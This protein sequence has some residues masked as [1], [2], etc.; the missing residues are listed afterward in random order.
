VVLTKILFE[1]RWFGTLEASGMDFIFMLTHGDKTVENCLETLDEVLPLGLGHIG[2]KD[3]GVPGD[4]LSR[5]TQRIRDAGATS[6]MEVVSETPEACLRSAHVAVELGV[7]RLLG[8][9]D[10]DAI[11]AILE[12]SDIAYYPF[13][14]FPVD[15]PTRLRGQ[16]EEI[17]AH[18]RKFMHAGAAGVDLLA[19]RATDADPM[20]LVR[21]ARAALDEGELIVAG[22]I[23]SP[24]QVC[25]LRDAGVDGF[26]IGPAVFDGAFHAGG[27]GIAAQVRAVLDCLR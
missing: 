20:A 10:I 2:F 27:D 3:I 18:C 23:D 12:G 5:L 19:Y 9:T 15:H 13:P 11:K 22:S 7:D 24:A 6:Y 4:K 14:G 16:P 26:T 8:G 17:A 1:T 25:A 21:A